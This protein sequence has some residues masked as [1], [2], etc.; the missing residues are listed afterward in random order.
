MGLLRNLPTRPSLP[1]RSNINELKDGRRIRAGCRTCSPQPHHTIARDRGARR[2]A[3]HRKEN[4]QLQQPRLA[5]R[6]DHDA[7]LRHSVSNRLGAGTSLR[8]CTGKPTFPRR[9][10]RDT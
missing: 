7:I 5:C 2:Y 10:A 4:R 3:W 9:P 8:N 6:F 1:F